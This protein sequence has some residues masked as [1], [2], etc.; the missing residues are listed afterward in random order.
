[1]QKQNLTIKYLPVEDL[2][3][4]ARNSRTHSSEQVAQL[5][6]SIK[7]FGF[8]NP[9]LVDA[10]KGVIAG[11]GRLMGA[12]KLG[13]KEVPTIEVTGWSDAKKRAYIIADNKLALNAGWDNELLKIE[14]EELAELGEVDLS[15][16]GFSDNELNSILGEINLDEEDEADLSFEYGLKISCANEG[17][18]SCLFDELQKRG[19]KCELLA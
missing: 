13:L 6:S 15:I 5:A 16:T 2:I 1:M 11:H 10:E 8:T 7:E 19:F 9:I 4:Y 3:P 12:Q 17:E 18:A 14:F